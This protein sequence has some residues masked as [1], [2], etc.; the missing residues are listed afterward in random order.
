MTVGYT[1][2]K[3]RTQR[4]MT[5]KQLADLIGIEDSTIRKYESGRLNAKPDT[6]EKI[7]KALDVDPETLIFSELNFNRAMHQLYRIIDNYGGEICFVDHEFVDGNGN[8]SSEK[9]ASVYFGALT[10]FI[11]ELNEKKRKLTPEE[12]EEYKN[13]FPASSDVPSTYLKTCVE[14][15]EK[16]KYISNNMQDGPYSSDEWDEHMKKLK[17]SSES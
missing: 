15:D 13:R 9:V 5:Q 4:K 7:A 3:I 11:E 6:L 1:I 10:P 17:G 16:L 12:F 8:T 14:F 2:K